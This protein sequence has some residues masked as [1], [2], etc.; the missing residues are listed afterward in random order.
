MNGLGCIGDGRLK[1]VNWERIMTKNSNDKI[2]KKFV[3]SILGV[4]MVVL[5]ITM[6]LS[7]WPDVVSFFKGISGIVIS[8]AGLTLLYFLKK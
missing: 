6:V 2:Y 1:I 7:F 8:I 4:L 5:G 3:L